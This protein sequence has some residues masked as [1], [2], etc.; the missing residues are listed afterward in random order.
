M[1]FGLRVMGSTRHRSAS[2]APTLLQSK[3]GGNGS[4]ITSATSSAVGY[5][6]TT[7]A[8]SLLVLVV[9]GQNTTA[10]TDAAISSLTPT[11]SGFSWISAGS[12]GAY[13]TGSGHTA[14]AVQIF[15]IASAASMAT[16]VH[17]TVVADGAADSTSTL[18][19]FSLYE[20]Y[21]LTGTK[22]TY[23]TGN[24]TASVP[25]TTNL[26]T[27]F[28][29]LIFVAYIATDGHST[30]GSGYTIGVNSTS[31]NYG[32]AQYILSDG[33]GSIATAFAGSRTV[34]AAAAVAF[35]I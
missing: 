13:S 1:N 15:Y 6:S 34:W 20:F 10:G 2:G 19:E 24:G 4:G 11:T 33:S 35:K 28:T 3:D 21:P 26:S 16:S 7:T 27:S 12:P 29:D 32:G 31:V 30:V 22:E 14:G 18:V 17:T 5:A 23:Q 25:S 9:W 8:G